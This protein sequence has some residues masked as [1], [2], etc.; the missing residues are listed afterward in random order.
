MKLQYEFFI[1]LL[2]TQ[3]MPANLPFPFTVALRG[4]RIWLG[5]FAWTVEPLII[6]VDKSYQAQTSSTIIKATTTA[7]PTVAAATAVAATPS[8]TST[9]T[10]SNSNGRN[11]AKEE[12][13]STPD[14]KT[15]TK[16]Q[17]MASGGSGGDKKKKGKQKSN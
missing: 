10:T 14:S 13:L 15:A 8:A 6:L 12:A 11:E 4:S 2:R 3:K 17:S 5:D 9:A 1:L 7:T 16:R